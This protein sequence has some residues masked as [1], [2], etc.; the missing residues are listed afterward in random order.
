LRLISDRPWK[1]LIFNPFELTYT[2]IFLCL[3]P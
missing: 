2:N 3:N 1:I